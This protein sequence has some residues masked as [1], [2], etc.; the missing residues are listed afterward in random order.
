MKEY[1]YVTVDGQ[2]GS[3]HTL[4]FPSKVESDLWD[5]LNGEQEYE[6]DSG[7]IRVIGELDPRELT[8]EADIRERFE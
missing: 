7:I 5:E 2:D 4:F 3:A 6:L 8:T 1:N